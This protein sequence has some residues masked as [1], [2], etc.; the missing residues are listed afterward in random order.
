MGKD[1][2]GVVEDITLR[3]IEPDKYRNPASVNLRAYIWT[4]DQETAF[5]LGCDL[6]YSVKSRFDRE[7]IEIPFPYRTLVFKDKSNVQ[8]ET[9]K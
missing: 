6:N 5:T 7:G 3:H 1:F 9:K 4:R 2:I 8:A